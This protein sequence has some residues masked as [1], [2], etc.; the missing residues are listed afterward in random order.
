MLLFFRKQLNKIIIIYDLFLIFKNKKIYNMTKVVNYKMD[1]TG[2][3]SYI[4][5]GNGGFYK[6]PAL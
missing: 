1:G 2:R 4:S 5:Y 3:D 6:T